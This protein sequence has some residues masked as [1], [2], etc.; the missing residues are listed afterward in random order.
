METEAFMKHLPPLLF[1]VS[2]EHRTLQF[3]SSGSLVCPCVL[4]VLC[5]LPGN[6]WHLLVCEKPNTQSWHSHDKWLYSVSISLDSA[7]D[8]LAWFY[9]PPSYH[10]QHSAFPEGKY[11]CETQRAKV[12]NSSPQV[13][14]VTSGDA[15]ETGKGVGVRT[16]VT[17]N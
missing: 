13:S 16:N 17:L 11:F 7:H 4:Q 12:Q 6:S 10:T 1:S 5:G 14:W 2:L 9:S 3:D 15:K 8:P